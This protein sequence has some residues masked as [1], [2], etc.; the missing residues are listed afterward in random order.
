MKKI[1]TESY[2]DF[3][4]KRHASINTPADLINE[5]VK[6]ATCTQSKSM[7]RIIIGEVNEVYEITLSSRKQIIVR[8]SSNESPRFLPEK[9][10]IEQCKKNKIPVPNVLLVE[11]FLDSDNKK[12]IC[13]EE[14]LPGQAL[15]SL[16]KDLKEKELIELLRKSGKVLS[17]IHTIPVLGFGIID[18]QGK[19]EFKTNEEYILKMRVE[20]KEKY[21]VA[22]ENNEMD[23]SIITRSFKYLE[24]YLD[25][26]KKTKSVLLHGD[27]SAQHLFFDEGM[28]TGVIDF[29]GACGGDPVRDLA[30]WDYFSPKTEYLIEGYTNK[31]FLAD[32]FEL[33]LHIYRL[34][35]G[36]GILNYYDYTN[37]ANGINHTKKMFDKDM[38]FFA[39]Y[40][41]R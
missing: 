41:K 29:E 32:N 30:W 15:S 24:K 22:A 40:E 4:K 11:N 39:S 35:V 20:N 28:L 23:V 17:S 5:F 10:A 19:G 8:I 9:W 27:F 3:L 16:I 1:K 26:Y 18:D 13:I 7:K 34:H 31:K 33:R 38:E 21:E 12:Q 6:K 14:K 25:V 36:L 2:E 37:N